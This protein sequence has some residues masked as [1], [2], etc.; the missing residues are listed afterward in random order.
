[1]TKIKNR[2]KIRPIQIKKHGRRAVSISKY[3]LDYL[4]G[5]LLTECNK[6]NVNVLQFLSS[7]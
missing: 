4:S 6:F 5:V 7:T 2:G 3:G 1:M